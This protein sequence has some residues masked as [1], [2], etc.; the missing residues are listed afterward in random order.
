MWFKTLKGTNDET[1]L[2]NKEIIITPIGTIK[3]IRLKE[4]NG[5]TI[6]DSKL[7]L[8]KIIEFKTSWINGEI[9]MLKM[10]DKSKT[11]TLSV[12]N[13]SEISPSLLPKALNIAISF[14]REIKFEYQTN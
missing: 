5:I 11:I 1:R 10:L 14:F 12:I 2:T 8:S 4:T 13:K 3:G 9:K 6:S 7:N